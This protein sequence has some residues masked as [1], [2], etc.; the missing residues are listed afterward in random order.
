LLA[1]V[2][3]GGGQTELAHVFEHN[4]VVSGVEGAFEVRVYDLNV[5]VANFCVLHHHDDGSEGVVFAAKETEAVVLFAEDTVGFCVF[6]A[7][8][9]D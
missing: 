9:F 1:S 2:D 7:C 5:F 6:V 4:A 8:I 3:K